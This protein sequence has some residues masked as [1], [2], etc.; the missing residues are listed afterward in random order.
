MNASEELECSIENALLQGD[1]YSYLRDLKKFKKISEEM[2]PLS[3]R[4]EKLL[5]TLELFAFGDIDLYEKYRS[6]YVNLNFKCFQKL[7][8]LTLLTIAEN[9]EG[10]S[11]PKSELVK[12]K[13]LGDAVKNY[14]TYTQNSSIDLFLERTLI[15][16]S[17]EK[18]IEMEI[19]D[20]AD[21]VLFRKLLFTRDAYDPRGIRLSVLK[22]NDIPERDLG[23]ALEKL[24]NWKV[25]NLDATENRIDFSNKDRKRPKETTSR[26]RK[27]VD[28]SY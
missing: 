9:L 28:S 22:K 6:Y 19:D 23:L 3:E 27:T 16:M 13:K 25:T 17:E 12:M 1:K 18:L 10:Q 21:S 11:I 24:K 15:R 20:V 2:N 14:E 7:I 8:I 5:N 26:K 4:S